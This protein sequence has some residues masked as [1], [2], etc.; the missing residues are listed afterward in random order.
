MRQTLDEES[1]NGLV[2]YRI[3]RSKETMSEARLMI[4]EGYLD[5]LLT[6]Y[7]MLVT[8]L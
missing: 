7:T 1:I 5:M 6:D 8:I 3:Q 2:T 4:D